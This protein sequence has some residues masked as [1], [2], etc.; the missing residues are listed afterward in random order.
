M[1][2]FY[3]KLLWGGAV[4]AQLTP[5]DSAGL[6]CQLDLTQAIYSDIAVD[7]LS[8][9]KNPL[10]LLFR[11]VRYK[12]DQYGSPPSCDTPENDECL[13]DGAALSYY[14]FYPRDH[15]YAEC[16]S[17]PVVI[18]HAGGFGECSSFD[19]PLINDLAELLAERGFVVFNVEYR[20]GVVRD[21]N[22]SDYTTA[23]QHLAPYRT[24]Q[25]IRGFIR[26]MIKRERNKSQFNDVWRIDT[27]DIFIG[28][29]SAGAFTAL[30]VAW[31]TN[32]MIYSLYALPIASANIQQVLGSPDADFYYGEPDLDFSAFYQPKIKGLFNCWG[33][34]PMP[35]AGY[36][37]INNQPSFFAS[38]HLTPAILFHG[39]NDDVFPFANLFPDFKQRVYLSPPAAGYDFN[40]VSFCIRTEQ[41]AFSVNDTAN[42]ADL[43]NGSSYNIFRVLNAY[44]KRCEIHVDC[45][46]EH[47][48][49]ADGSGYSSNFGTSATNQYQTAVYMASRIAVF[50]QKI[51]HPPSTWGNMIFVECENTSKNCDTNTNCTNRNCNGDNIFPED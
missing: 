21:S 11:D 17:K 7:T 4:N 3:Y 6:D 45:Q 13:N 35:H 33:A 15:N 29:T 43:I 48:L 14:V 19:L 18:M 31:Y 49:D 23:Q 41:G 1:H 9:A 34:I 26:S 20:R 37:N 28:G 27:N 30:N 39:F 24:I 10:P 40:T 42:T 47:G 50:F 25:D 22:N 51:L 12:L 2:C 36:S 16:P 32:S 46:M 38:A 5:C 44:S 8:Y